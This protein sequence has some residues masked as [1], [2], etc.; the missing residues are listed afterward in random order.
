MRMALERLSARPLAADDI[1]EAQPPSKSAAM[2]IEPARAMTEAGCCRLAFALE[3]L[4]LS[5]V[6]GRAFKRCGAAYST[7]QGWQTLTGKY[8]IRR[9]EFR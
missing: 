2:R 8:A 6:I 4:V 7:V 1:M 5:I 9:V 3:R